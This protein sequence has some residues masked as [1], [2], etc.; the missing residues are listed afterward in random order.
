MVVGIVPDQVESLVQ[1]V[2]FLTGSKPS[3][4][5]V[6]VS[7]SFLFHI[8]VVRKGLGDRGEKQVVRQVL[9]RDLCGRA[10]WIVLCSYD[11]HAKV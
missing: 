5:F 4:R 1:V 10:S 9:L 8:V 7:R 6:V 11:E 2:W 3:K